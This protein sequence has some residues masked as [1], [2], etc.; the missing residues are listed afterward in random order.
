MAAGSSATTATNSNSRNIPAAA[1]TSLD[2]INTRPAQIDTRP[3]EYWLVSKDGEQDWPVV[4]CDEEIVQKYF[5]GPRPENASVVD[6]T[7]PELFQPGGDLRQSFCFP[8]LY[9]GTLEL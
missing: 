9:L 7:W 8:I 3:G 5:K 6:G 4:I 1:R 2:D